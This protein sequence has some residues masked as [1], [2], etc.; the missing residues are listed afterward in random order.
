MS[1]FVAFVL[2]L[3]TIKAWY[4]T[5]NV[6]THAQA[7]SY[8]NHYCSSVFGIIHDAQEYDQVKEAIQ[9]TPNYWSTQQNIWIGLS[10]PSFPDFQWSDDTSLFDSYFGNNI[11]GGIFPW[12]NNEPDG[13]GK[14]CVMMRASV[15]YQWQD[16]GC[17]SA[18]Q[19]LCN[20]CDS[21]LHKYIISTDVTTTPHEECASTF[22]TSLANIY[23]Q[24]DHNEAQTLCSLS[25]KSCWVNHDDSCAELDKNT[26][27]QLNDAPCD[28][29]TIDTHSVLCE[30]PSELCA[31]SDWGLLSGVMAFANC[32]MS[33]IYGDAVLSDKQWYNSNGV[34]RMDYMFRMDII[35]EGGHSGVTIYSSLCDYYYVSISADH[36]SVFYHQ[37]GHNTHTLLS[38]PLMV[39]AS[40]MEYYLMSITVTNRKS[41]E[42]SIN[43]IHHIT[44]VDD[45]TSMNDGYSGYIG[46]TSSGTNTQAKSLYVSGA[47]HKTDIATFDAAEICLDPPPT[48]TEFISTTEMLSTEAIITTTEMLTTST[49]EDIVTTDDAT[50]TESIVLS[51][52]EALVTTDETTEMIAATAAELTENILIAIQENAATTQRR[53][54]DSMHVK[55]ESTT[56]LLTTSSDEHISPKH[57]FRFPS[58]FNDTWHFVIGF[59][60]CCLMFC[61]VAF[62]L[63]NKAQGIVQI[64]NEKNLARH[65]DA[66]GNNGVNDGSYKD[67]VQPTTNANAIDLVIMGE[68][69]HVDNDSGNNK[70]N[71]YDD[72]F[73]IQTFGESSKNSVESSQ[74]Y[75]HESV[76]IDISLSTMVDSNANRKN[77]VLSKEV[78]SIAFAVVETFGDDSVAKEE[79]EQ[80]VIALERERVREYIES[81]AKHSQVRLAP[82]TPYNSCVDDDAFAIE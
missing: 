14:R 64:A 2:L 78:E 48:T 7:E 3:S 53:D 23:T 63:L 6:F 47:V 21:V 49:T 5:D 71:E 70:V 75:Y 31:V 29:N 56:A 66:G 72:E 25:D 8:C 20:T 82:V 9:I 67:G 55:E 10:T 19:S 32:Q 59:V 76:D 51:T 16:T 36:V 61:C 52:T 58:F 34:L 80:T 54:I 24:N 35:E 57:A 42:V 12:A 60:V 79:S 22:G 27:Y 30:R 62:V 17:R 28:N 46:L 41:F 77:D 18:K 65:I 74:K 45:S 43:D 13:T 33:G 68:K 50:T 1:S 26:N 73:I 15:D 11:T 39:N 69:A 40:Q 44:Y 4:I 37:N 81:Y 38:V